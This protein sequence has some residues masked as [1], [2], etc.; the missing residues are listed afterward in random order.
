MPSPL[1]HLLHA[2]KYTALD[3]LHENDPGLT[4][5]VLLG[6][7]KE[8]LVSI[9]LHIW[10]LFVSHLK[11]PCNVVVALLILLRIRMRLRLGGCLYVIIG[12]VLKS[13]PVD[14]FSAVSPCIFNVLVKKIYCWM[15]IM[16]IGNVICV[17]FMTIFQQVIVVYVAD[18]Y[19][20]IID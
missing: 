17:S 8:G 19:E 1:Q 12:G 10:H 4:I 6:S 7:M 15:K 20:F 11:F 2:S 3:E 18:L 13:F 5:D 9:K 14:G 16:N